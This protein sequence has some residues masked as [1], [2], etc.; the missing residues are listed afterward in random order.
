[1][2]TEHCEVGI[3]HT[4]KARK[5]HRCDECYGTIQPGETYRKCTGVFDGAGFTHKMCND[6]DAL[7]KEMNE[8][9]DFE[10]TVSFGDLLEFASEEGDEYLRRFADIK[11]KRGVEIPRWMEQRLKG[12]EE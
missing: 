12:E 4:P 9:K 10:D 8:G 2:S 1:M 11:R 5:P 3:W 7:I 6:C